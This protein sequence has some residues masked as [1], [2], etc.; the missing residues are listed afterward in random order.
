MEGDIAQII[1]YS[2][3]VRRYLR[4]GVYAFSDLASIRR[5]FA[6][7][8]YAFTTY[9][10]MKTVGRGESWLNGAGIGA[11]AWCGVRSAVGLVAG[12]VK[13]WGDVVEHEHGYRAQFAKPHSISRQSVFIGDTHA[14]LVSLS[15]LYGVR[16]VSDTDY[17]RDHEF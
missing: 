9:Q 5:D 6:N 7:L 4:G 16:I 11:D 14:A 15:D 12:T 8:A 1:G 13:L 2:I 17:R 3:N 10:R